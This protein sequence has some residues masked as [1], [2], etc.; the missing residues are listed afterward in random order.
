MAS[1]LN[2]KTSSSIYCQACGASNPLQATH[3]FACYEP[4]TSS[5]GG[6]KAITNPLNGLLLPDVVINQ[7]YRILEVLSTDDV[8]TV[9][10]AEDI[11]LG[12]RVVSLKE[13]GGNNQSMPVSKTE[14]EV[15]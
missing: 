1:N 2:D 10:K 5:G 9:Y 7:R 14:V 4:L 13:I 3:C 15:S 6:T 8:S 11:Q 12:C